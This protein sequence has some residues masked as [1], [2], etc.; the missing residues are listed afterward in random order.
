MLMGTLG[1]LVFGYLLTV[2]I[3]IPILVAGFR[4]KYPTS[5]TIVIGLL[6][7]GVTYPVVVMVLPGM[8][9]AAG[10]DS[11]L[12]YLLIAE[13]FAPVG[14][15]LFFR[16]LTDKPL[17]RSLDRDALVIVAA[18]LAS[19][20]MGEAGLSRWLSTMVGNS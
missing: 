1:F 16:Y 2:L 17:W 7:T 5:E 10:S 14:E 13:T 20:L 4:G 18:N 11:R 3:E 15:V 6:L 19:F 12:V 9:Q 8:F